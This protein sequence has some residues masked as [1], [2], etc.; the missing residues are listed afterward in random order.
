M[1]KYIYIYLEHRHTI[2]QT[3]LNTL[4]KTHKHIFRQKYHKVRKSF[5]PCKKGR[6]IIQEIVLIN[7]YMINR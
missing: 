2:R 1:Q 4:K 3:S 7:G 5:I 6:N